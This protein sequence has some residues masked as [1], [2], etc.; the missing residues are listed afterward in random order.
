MSSNEL[1]FEYVNQFLDRGTGKTPEYLELVQ[2]K[3]KFKI[4]FI[5]KFY[6]NQEDG[7]IITNIKIKNVLILFSD[8]K[9]EYY[10]FEN[11]NMDTKEQKIYDLT[12]RVIFKKL[13][14]K[15]ISIHLE[16]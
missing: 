10:D 3:K 12:E 15:S 8:D 2:Y 1:L 14:S 4:N 16:N 5:C 7:F 11:K 13:L 9:E 6:K